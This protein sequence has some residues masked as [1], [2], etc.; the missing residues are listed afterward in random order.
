MESREAEELEKAEKLR[1]KEANKLRKNLKLMDSK[2][3][4]STSWSFSPVIPIYRQ[5]VIRKYSCVISAYD[6][7]S[8]FE[9]SIIRFVHSIQRGKVTTPSW[10]RKR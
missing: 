2:L 4:E 8:Y 1:K 7:A 5:G 6:L 9:N 10:K 3:K